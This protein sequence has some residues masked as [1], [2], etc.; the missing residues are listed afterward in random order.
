M[1]LIDFIFKLLFKFAPIDSVEYGKLR[2]EGQSWY[3]NI[4]VENKETNP[5]LRKIKL[6]SE[7]W[8]AKVFYALAFIIGV[9][10]IQIF[11]NPSLGGGDE[12]EDDD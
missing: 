1:N 11:M 4:N 10:Q 12:E 9:R 7:N 8:Y 6:F 5:I 2:E 3:N